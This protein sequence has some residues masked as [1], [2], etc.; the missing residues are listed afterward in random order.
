MVRDVPAGLAVSTGFMDRDGDPIDF[1]IAHH[2]FDVNK[3]RLED[4]GLLIPML[5]AQGVNLESGSRAKAF[6]S[7]LDEYS[8]SV[9]EGTLEL[10]SEYLTEDELPNAAMKFLALMIRVR[11]FE[12]LSPE[13]VENTFR[14][15]AKKAI[16][17]YFSDIAEVTFKAQLAAD[18]FVADALIVPKVSSA[19]TIVVYFATSEAKVDEAVM[20]W[21]DQKIKNKNVYEI[22]LLLEHEK[23]SGI[24]GRAIRRAMNRVGMATF[25]GDE[26]AAMARIASYGGT[27][28]GWVQ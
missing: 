26:N 12:L 6:Q 2:P 7:L 4:S 5:E 17:E 27:A 25:R 28:Q 24:S 23:P 3:F 21:Q 8:V 22:A 20:F 13:L 16:S 9:D 14:D 15:D 19:K 11:D 18:D 10:Y 1:Y